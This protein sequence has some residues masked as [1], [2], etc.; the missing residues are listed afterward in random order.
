M[1]FEEKL[2]KLE[3]ISNNMREENRPLEESINASEEGIKSASELEKELSTFEKR[4]QILIE[5]DGDDH[6]EDFK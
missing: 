1:K 6:L 4:V 3:K 5:K 2:E